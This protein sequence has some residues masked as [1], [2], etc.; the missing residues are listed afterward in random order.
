MVEVGRD[1]WRTSSPIPSIKIVPVLVGFLTIVISGEIGNGQ[2]QD[3]SSR[4]ARSS[5]K[6]V[7]CY[8]GTTLLSEVA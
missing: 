1:V 8:K 5:S 6:K 2:F 3:L 4:L 7:K